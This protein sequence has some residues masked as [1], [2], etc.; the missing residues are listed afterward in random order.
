MSNRRQWSRLANESNTRGQVCGR[1]HCGPLQLCRKHVFNAYDVNANVCVCAGITIVKTQSGRIPDYFIHGRCAKYCN[2]LSVCLSSRISRKPH[3]FSFQ[4]IFS[5]CYT[6]GWGTVLVWRQCNMLCT[7][8]YVG[9][10][11]FC[12]DITQRMGQF[13]RWRQRGR[14]LP[15]PTASCC[16]CKTWSMTANM[17]DANTISCT[18][19]QSTDI[20]AGALHLHIGIAPASHAPS[21]L[22]NINATEPNDGRPR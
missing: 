18:W 20:R 17:E 6:Y 7:S 9:E 8:G 21:L 14:S 5:T 12:F 19:L 2:R 1:P 13:A 22:M 3:T 11:I 4:Q 16:V 15:S 10:V